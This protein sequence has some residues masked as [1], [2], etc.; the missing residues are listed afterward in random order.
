MKRCFIILAAIFL[1]S[2]SEPSD[3]QNVQPMSESVNDLWETLRGTYMGTYYLMDTDKV[4]YTESITFKP[5]SDLVHIIPLYTTQEGSVYAYG[6]AEI[7]DSRFTSISGISHCYYVINDSYQDEILTI[8]FY[9]FDPNTENILDIVN[10]ED[11]RNIK[12]WS[13][14]QFKMWDY[15]S[16]EAE[17]AVNYLKQ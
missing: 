5:Y 15:G 11:K 2:C 6:E 8:S 13:S 9:E 7:D 1:S 4:W 17:N 14:S 12:D 10:D 3:Q 16:T